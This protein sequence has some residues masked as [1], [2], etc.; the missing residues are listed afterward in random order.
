MIYGKKY[1]TL[2]KISYRSYWAYVILNILFNRESLKS[3]TI[4]DISKDTGFKT[5]DIIS[6]LHSLNM[7]KLWKG[8]HVIAF[9]KT[10]VQNHLK[11]VKQIRLCNPEYLTWQ[12]SVVQNSK[13]KIV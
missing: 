11:Q 5:E 8:Q 9:N 1:N 12:P 4:A 13:K 7:I 3:I 10:A 2:G 6:T